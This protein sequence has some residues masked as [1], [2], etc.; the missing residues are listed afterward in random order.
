MNESITIL[1]LFDCSFIIFIFKTSS[2]YNKLYCLSSIKPFHLITRILFSK[3]NPV[4]LN[5]NNHKKIYYP[6]QNFLQ[7]NNNFHL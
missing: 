4:Y 2:E 3:R 6:G 1:F 7:R 5:N